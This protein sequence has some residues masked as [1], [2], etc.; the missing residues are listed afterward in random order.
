[1]LYLEYIKSMNV[2]AIYRGLNS[3][4]KITKLHKE[5]PL[6]PILNYTINMAQ[7]IQL[8]FDTPFQK[9]NYLFSSGYFIIFL[10]L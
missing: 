10:H 8:M 2:P 4:H 7:I 9:D 6:I 3:L 5:E 1:M